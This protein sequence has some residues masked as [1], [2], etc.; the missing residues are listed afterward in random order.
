MDQ[1][2]KPVPN[3]GYDRRQSW[4][5]ECDTVRGVPIRTTVGIGPQIVTY[6]CPNCAREWHVQR[7]TPVGS[8]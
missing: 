7:S 4:C 5:P 2:A 6:E 1:P 3:G 8:W